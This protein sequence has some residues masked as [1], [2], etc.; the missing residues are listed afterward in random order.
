MKPGG[1]IIFRDYAKYDAAQLR[2]KSGSKLEENLYVRQDGTMAYYFDQAEL[3]NLFSDNGFDPISI[4]PIYKE[5][6]NRKQELHM[7]RIFLQAKFIKR[8]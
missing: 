1:I 6:I 8:A 4:D 5:T 7:N 3:F 2:F